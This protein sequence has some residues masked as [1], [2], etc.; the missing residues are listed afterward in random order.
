VGQTRWRVIVVSRY[1]SSDF[2]D[3]FEED[4]GFSGCRSFHFVATVGSK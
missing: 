2:R 1:F 3:P 4:R